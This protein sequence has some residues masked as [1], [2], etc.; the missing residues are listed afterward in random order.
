MVLNFQT[1]TEEQLDR[2]RSVLVDGQTLLKVD[3]DL[4]KPV[5]WQSLSGNPPFANLVQNLILHDDILVDSQLLLINPACQHTANLFGYAIKALRI[6]ADLRNSIAGAL[7]R[8]GVI[9]GDDTLE[10]LSG[11]KEL[12]VFIT[13]RDSEHVQRQKGLPEDLLELPEE[14]WLDAA[15]YEYGGSAPELENTDMTAFRA[16]FYLEL[17]RN[18]QLYYAPHPLRAAY[19]KQ[20]VELRGEEVEDPNKYAGIAVKALNLAEGKHISKENPFA[21]IDISIPPVAEYVA[22]FSKKKEIGMNVAIQEVRESR[23]ARAF[24][25]WC[26]ERNSIIRQGRAGLK[27]AQRIYKELDTL[28]LKWAK[29]IQEEVRYRT[30]T[31]TWSE[32][33]WMGSIVKSLEIDKI[34]KLVGWH[35]REIKDPVLWVKQPYLL[36]L[37]DL[38]QQ[39]D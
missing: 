15:A 30:R 19:F 20:I 25:K 24:R 31:I 23:N 16:H 8:T 29:D 27:D 7:R 2:S 22:R 12:V 38:Y 3:R 10:D 21:T 32:L 17:S 13:R 33:P 5:S 28:C 34:L 14:D 4:E 26:A 35:R 37:N 9:P 18:L 11:N 39:L 1:I 6:K 36:F